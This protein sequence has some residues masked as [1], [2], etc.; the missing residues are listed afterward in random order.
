MSDFMLGLQIF[1]QS[2]INWLIF[3][4]GLIGGL[5][6]GAIP[7]LNAIILATILLPFTA[8]LQP[9]QAIMLLAV[10]YCSGVYGGAV[11]AIL[12][13]IPGS[14]E[15]AP[16]AF[17]GYPMTLKGEA[18]KAIGA[19]VTCS[20]IGGTVSVLIMMVA[21]APIA[22]WAI[23]AFGP[24]EIFALIVFA[25]TVSSAVGAKDLWRGWLSVGFGLLIATIGTDA[26][27]GLRRFDFGN[28]YLGAG[29]H[30]VP[31]ILGFFAVSEVLVQSRHIATGEY[32]APKASLDF[33]S[34]REFWSVRI[35]M[36]RS[37]IIGFF[38]GL[39]PGIGA[40]LAAFLSYSEAV[41]WSKHPEKF[42]RGTLEGVVAPETA[43]NA[44]TGGAM[45]PLLALGLPGGAL[46]AVM[47]G[48]F[49]IHGME[50]GPMVLVTSKELVWVVF[51]A[52]L[53]ANIAIFLLGWL[54]TKTTVHLLRI[55]FAVLG[56]A[57]LL[58]SVIGTYALRTLVID[59][60]VMFIAGIVGYFM[61]RSGYSMAG[62]VLGLI[63]GKIGESAWVKTMQMVDYSVIGLFQ[64][65]I[66]AFLLVLAALSV[67]LSVRSELNRRGRS[68]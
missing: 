46:T 15:N 28:A 32:K 61:R 30:F 1:T 67:V 4:G 5:V 43:N 55:P 62:V 60:W 49:Q 29:I 26:A 33:P 14:P 21:T 51:V 23:R 20:A 36:L 6:F 41:R 12:F 57:I 16:T 58:V 59:V 9:E 45:I 42:G 53:F 11:T 48:A 38:A 68:G 56:P 22:G 34:L 8:Y 63:L 19:A 10:I 44:A 47:V 2:P 37:V 18:G 50:P 65:P 52:M 35:T 25:L 17:D 40:T 13:N 7:G 3:F 54:E 27:G 39:L 24:P 64:R 66:T 31:L